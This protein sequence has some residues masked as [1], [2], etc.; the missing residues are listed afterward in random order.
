MKSSVLYHLELAESIKIESE[1]WPKA[2]ARAPSADNDEVIPTNLIFNNVTPDI[3]D[4][5][6][7]QMSFG[8]N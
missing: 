4:G 7:S 6:L 3:T 2:N 1:Y 8:L 5:L